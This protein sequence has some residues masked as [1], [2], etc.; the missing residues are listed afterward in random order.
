MPPDP[1][2]TDDFD[3]ALPAELIAQTPVE[4]RDSSR[5]LVLDRANGAIEHAAFRDLPRYLRSGDLLVANESRVFPARLF[6][7]KATGGKVELLLLRQRDERTW[8]ALVRGKGIGEGARLSF[9]PNERQ[10]TCEV[11]ATLPHGGR[12]LQFDQ[13]V[14]PHLIEL[15]AVPLP[16][17][18]HRQLE[19]SERYQTVYSVTP[20]SA[21][22]PTAG[23]HFTPE[24]IAELRGHGVEWTTVTLHVGLDTFRPVQVEEI[25]HH[26]M[27]SEAFELGPEAASAINRARAEGRR[28][29]AVGTTAV[30]VL[31]TV[32]RNAE[33]AGEPIQPSR[34]DTDIFIYPPY[35]FRVVDGLITNFHLPRSTLLMLVSALAGRDRIRHAYAEAI[36]ERYR[37]FSFGDAMLIL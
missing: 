22:A 20:G 7:Y 23:L 10:L 27:H 14:E 3:Y 4:P 37:F 15:G 30:R 12:L 2:R 28:V 1:L 33:A 26:Q 36:R 16:P 9:G 13:P 5:L 11:V 21:A 8:E 34:G 17:Y 35:R 24:L 29:I 31:E 25:V 6:G 18:I 19:D 32:G